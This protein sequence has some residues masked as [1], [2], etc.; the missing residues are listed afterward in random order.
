MK[1]HLVL[2]PAL[3]LLLH[4]GCTEDPAASPPPPAGAGTTAP[5]QPTLLVGEFQVDPRQYWD[6]ART[7]D[8]GIV[9]PRNWSQITENLP[10]TVRLYMVRHGVIDETGN[11]LDVGLM[12]EQ[13]PDHPR[14]LDEELSRIVQR[15][16]AEQQVEVIDEPRAQTLTLGDGNEARLLLIELLI[17]DKTTRRSVNAKLVT[18]DQQKNAWVV[19]GYVVAGQQSVVATLQSGIFQRLLAHVE[20][21]SLDPKQVNELQVHEVYHSPDP[22]AAQQ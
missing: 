16:R 1:M 9:I 17:H 14:T 4:S 13:F 15:Y 7:E 10:P 2:F 19:S 18:I 8:F 22:A 20:S 12:I 3:A 6:V 5:P 11:P 21:F